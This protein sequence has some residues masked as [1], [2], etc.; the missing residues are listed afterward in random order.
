MSALVQQAR[1]YLDTPFRHRG[2]TARGLDCAGLGW[3]VYADLG[4]ELPDIERYGREPWNNGLMQGLEAA[5]GA[6]VWAGRGPARELLQVGDVVVIAWVREP[7]H[8]ALVGDDLIHGLSLI[9]ADG[10]LG[11]RRVVEHGLDDRYL[12]LIVAIFRRPV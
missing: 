6:P 5:L 3:R 11:V 10:T 12:S 2:R 4:V 9:H 7:H 8:V 1:A